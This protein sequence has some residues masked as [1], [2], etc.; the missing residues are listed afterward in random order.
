[1]LEKIQFQ[2]TWS[3]PVVTSRRL[4][5]QDSW[6]SHCVYSCH[7]AAHCQL[8]HRGR[9]IDVLIMHHKM[10]NAP[11][12]A[13][14][15]AMENLPTGAHHEGRRFLLME[16]AERLEIR[17]R[18]PEWKIRTDDLDDVVRSADLPRGNF[19]CAD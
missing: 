18:A 7:P 19:A 13:T 17:S 4:R 8:A 14:A 11:A 10:K 5:P 12:C 9:K 1:M 6:S 3:F 15:E 16:G 2:G